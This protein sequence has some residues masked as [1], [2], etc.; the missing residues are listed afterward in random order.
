MESFIKIPTDFKSLHDLKDLV[1]NYD[2]VSR[3]SNALNSYQKAHIDSYLM[4][5]DEV[6]EYIPIKHHEEY[7][8][9]VGEKEIS[10]VYI[11]YDKEQKDLASKL[12]YAL[13]E[14]R[15]YNGS[16]W[17][18]EITLVKNHKQERI[19]MVNTIKKEINIIY[20]YTDV[21]FCVKPRYEFGKIQYEID[22][23]RI[24]SVK[25]NFTFTDYQQVGGAS[26]M[27]L[28]GYSYYRGGQR[29]PYTREGYE[30][31]QFDTK[32]NQYLG[33]IE[34]VVVTPEREWH[35]ERY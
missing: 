23:E 27:C 22:E 10:S 24:L 21:T 32:T 15:Y 3:L 4:T 11:S 30:I 26:I 12:N 1:N 29:V 17:Q 31:Y 9:M 13:S 14:K 20:W 7:K 19:F 34:S 35:K 25:V 8:V 5:I 33:Y 16:K 6:L 28:T 2:L 18:Y